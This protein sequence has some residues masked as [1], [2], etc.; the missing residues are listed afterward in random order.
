MSLQLR[1][2]PDLDLRRYAAEYQARGFVQVPALFESQSAETLSDLL[3]HRTPWRLTFLDAGKPVSYTQA[4]IAEVGQEAFRAKMARVTEN[5]RNDYGYS[6]YHY[7]MSQA[8]H[9]QW[10]GG[11]PIHQLTDFLDRDAFL[12]VGRAITGESGINKTEA[13]ASLYAA[14]SFLTRHTDHGDGARRA[15][16][17][18]GLSKDWRPDW[19]GLLLFYNEHKDVIAGYTPRFNVVTIF[20]TKYEHAV[21]QVSNFAGG[22]RYSIAGW[23][24]DDPAGS[25]FT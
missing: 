12:D 20:D 18:I 19:G 15:A 17:V 7:P 11:H 22:G 1:L 4:G 24:R 14:G 16:Y 5:A 8:R 9:Q 23:F 10:D 21:T 25:V 3:L 13:M 2:S 6:F